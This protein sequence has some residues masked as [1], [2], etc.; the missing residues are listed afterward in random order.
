LKEGS[1]H[2]LLLPDFGEVE[3]MRAVVQRVTQAAVSVNGV[4]TGRIGRGLLIY[5]G[6]G[7]ADKQADLTY[8]VHKAAGL[9]IFADDNGHMN[10]SVTDVGGSALVIS[11]FTLFGDVRRGKRPS[12]TDAMEPISAN[13]MYEAFVT[14]LKSCG[15][16]CAQGV[17]GAM[18]AVQ[19]VNDG[20]VTILLDSTKLF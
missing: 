20:P 11:Q 2:G 18:M 17:F 6:V 8:L 14:G 12:F 13:Q 3:C 4:E 5:L 7:A 9:R 10:R 15:V 1:A 19:S 16:P